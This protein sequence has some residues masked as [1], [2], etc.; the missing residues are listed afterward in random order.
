[1]SRPLLAVLLCLAVPLPAAAQGPSGA[2][3]PAGPAIGGHDPVAYFSGTPA[4]GSADFTTVHAGAT[5]RFASAAN[6]TAFLADPQR[7]LPQFG[8]NCA[9][10]ASQGR[11]AKPDP[12]IW[13]VVGG[14]LYLNCSPEAEAKWLADV[15]GNISRAEAFWATQSK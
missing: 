9:W 3:Q 15:P 7:Y 1:M 6:R 8:G 14:K 5:Y 10:A 13:R 11:L 2:V 12:K 4:L